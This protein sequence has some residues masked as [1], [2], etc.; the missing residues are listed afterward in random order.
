MK[1]LLYI[2][3]VVNTKLVKLGIATNPVSRLNALQTGCPFKL[4]LCGTVEYDGP[5]TVLEAGLHEMFNDLHV[6]GEWFQLGDDELDLITILY[7]S[8][9]YQTE[10]S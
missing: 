8:R 3:R 4:E 5:A 9:L 1:Q 10:K 7:D 2:I 6:R